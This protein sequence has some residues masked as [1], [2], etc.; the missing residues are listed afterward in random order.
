MITKTKGIVLKTIKYGD[1]SAITKIFTEEFGL[2][3]FHIPSLF[4]NKGRIKPSHLQALNCVEIS[5]NLSNAK[6]LYAIKDLTCHFHFSGAQFSQQAYYN[7]IVEL[8]TQSIKE[9]EHNTSLFA[10]LYQQLIPSLN[11][12]TGYWQLPTA[13]LQILY[14]YGCAPNTDG[15]ENNHVLDLQ[16]GIFSESF[17]EA[18]YTANPAVSNVIYNILAHGSDQL[19]QDGTLRHQTIEALID[20]FRLHLNESFDLKSR[21]VLWQVMKG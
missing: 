12:H 7:V 3:G 1:A 19:S 5:F 20:Y 6:N 9:N 15:Y 8:I 18:Y 11:E 16:N 4:K 2:I 13:M 17:L 14:H 10:Y 21:E